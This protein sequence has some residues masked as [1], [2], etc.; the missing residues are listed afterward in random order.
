M[1]ANSP[2]R[3][4][5]LGSTGSVGQ[6]TLDIVRRNRDL[7][8]VTA[9]T[10]RGN[11][12]ELISQANE[13]RPEVVC[14]ESPELAPVVERELGGRVSVLSGSEGLEQCIGQ[15]T[16]TAV[17]VGIVGFAGL[18]AVLA[19]IKS[20]KHVA[21]A[22]KESLVAG[23]GLVIEALRAS[24]VKLVPVDSE[25]S[26]IY[27]CLERNASTADVRRIILTASGGPFLRLSEEELRFVTPSDAIRHP[28]WR[29]GPKI[30][31]DCATMMNKGLE[32]I[33]ASWLFELPGDKIDILIHPE[34]VVHGMVEYQDGMIVSGLSDTDMRAPIA[35]ALE[36]LRR[37]SADASPDAIGSGVSFLNWAELGRLHFAEPDAQ[38]ATVLALCYDALREGGTVP[39][40]LNAANEEAVCAF[41][42]EEISFLDITR[43]VRE[44][45]ESYTN[46]K[47]GTLSDVLIADAWGRE[48]ASKIIRA[49]GI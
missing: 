47:I 19:A 23:G 24:K 31:V 3:I 40:V 44:V 14:V 38:Q 26:T 12:A 5:V 30:S 7:L 33:E 9:L 49:R 45:V 18:S 43:V 27:R 22:N 15:T 46:T 8:Q 2:T 48:Q 4:A 36:R 11:T 28:R 10:A 13:F 41:L 25:H 39:A 42:H 29:M 34:S 20:G 1:S 6:A 37:E 17:V 21:L 16:A 35:F 32:V